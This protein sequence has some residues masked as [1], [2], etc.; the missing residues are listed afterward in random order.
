MGPFFVVTLQQFCGDLAHLFQR[1]KHKGIEH[2]CSIGPIIALDEGILIRFPR[3]NI[4]QLDRPLYT[5]G[6]EALGEELRSIVEA[7]R[8]RL[9]PPGHHLPQ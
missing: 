6:D 8:L 5:P 9:A 2:F 7:K 1:L 4:A 3:L